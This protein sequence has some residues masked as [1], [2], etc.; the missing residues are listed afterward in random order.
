MLQRFSIHDETYAIRTCLYTSI[1][2]VLFIRRSRRLLKRKRNLPGSGCEEAKVLYSRSL[3]FA[4]V[5]SGRTTTPPAAA[6]A[7]I[8]DYLAALLLRIPNTRRVQSEEKSKKKGKKK[9]QMSLSVAFKKERINGYEH[10]LSL[11]YKIESTPH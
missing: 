8:A 10:M 4:L 3:C 5:G 11:A 2:V 9:Q 6:A 1:K 7:V